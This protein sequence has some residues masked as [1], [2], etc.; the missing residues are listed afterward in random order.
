MI[1]FL[2]V[3]EV[4]R[5]HDFHI[6]GLGGLSDISS[7]ATGLSNPVL[8]N[9]V[10]VFET[11]IWCLFVLYMILFSVRERANK[12]AYNFYHFHINFFKLKVYDMVLPSLTSGILITSY[13]LSKI[14]KWS[15]PCSLFRYLGTHISNGS[16]LSYETSICSQLEVGIC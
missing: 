4:K 5:S 6:I 2:R 9:H 11:N 8:S 15:L 16:N 1:L 13:Y 7:C 3:V 12:L 10:Y 14:C